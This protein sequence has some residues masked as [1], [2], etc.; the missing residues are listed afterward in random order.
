MWDKI[1]FSRLVGT[2][3]LIKNAL[4]VICIVK[5]VAAA[6]GSL[7][8]SKIYVINDKALNTLQSEEIRL[9]LI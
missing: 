8:S 1:L 5:N 7:P 3:E 9:I 6:A 2:V 4:E